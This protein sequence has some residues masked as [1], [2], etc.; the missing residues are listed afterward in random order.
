[1]GAQENSRSAGA[2]LNNPH[3]LL[4]NLDEQLTKEDK[5]NN[6]SLIDQLRLALLLPQ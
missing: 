4:Q 1:L 5:A 3:V 6:Q 2:S